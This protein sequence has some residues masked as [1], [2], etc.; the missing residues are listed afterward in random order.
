MLI[1]GENLDKTIIKIV[2]REVKI[3]NDVNNINE[4][5]ATACNLQNMQEM[6]NIER[7]GKEV[8]RRF[9]QHFVEKIMAMTMYMSKNKHFAKN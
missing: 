6:A 8:E 3:L 1:N 4:R 9:N 5:Y 7:D 2:E